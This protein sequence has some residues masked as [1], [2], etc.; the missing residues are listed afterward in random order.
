MKK[1][2]KDPGNEKKLKLY[3]LYKQ[4]TEGDGFLVLST[5]VVGTFVAAILFGGSLLSYNF[6]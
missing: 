6:V 5:L 4:A 1:L 3:A 2:K